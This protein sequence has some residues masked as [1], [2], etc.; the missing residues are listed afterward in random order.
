MH[1]EL[2]ARRDT[3][4][5]CPAI[6][7]AEGNATWPA[8]GASDTEVV[9]TCLPGYTGTPTRLC[10]GT[11]T[12]PGVWGPVLTDCAGTGPGPGALSCGVLTA[13]FVGVYGATTAIVCPNVDDSGT[14]DIN[15][16]F[17][18][19]VA[20]TVAVGTCAPGLFGL[21]Q[22]QCQ[23]DG[24]WAPSL[25]RNPCSGPSHVQCMQPGVRR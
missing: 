5:T 4:I 20:G 15:A 14:V 19:A 23:L 10:T 2:R 16:T 22:R 9:G 3:E 25:L 7:T 24:F 18:T 11:T 8:S 13:A 12:S 6:S 1:A 21:P 17:S